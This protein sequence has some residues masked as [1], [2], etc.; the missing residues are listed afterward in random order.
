MG[1]FELLALHFEWEHLVPF[2]DIRRAER[3]LK[4][5]AEEGQPAVIYFF[6]RRSRC[7]N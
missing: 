2:R 1:D 3:I 4:S 7:F 6:D 5:L